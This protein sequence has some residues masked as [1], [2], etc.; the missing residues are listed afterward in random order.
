M[1]KLLR[2]FGGS[3]QF[4]SSYTSGNQSR[5]ETSARQTTQSKKGSRLPYSMLNS[6]DGRLD[7][8]QSSLLFSRQTSAIPS[9]LFLLF[10]HLITLFSILYLSTFHILVL[11]ITSSFPSLSRQPQLWEEDQL[12]TIINQSREAPRLLMMSRQNN[13][14]QGSFLAAFSRRLSLIE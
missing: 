3:K 10:P 7:T 9:I 5:K 12:Y 8:T 2:W 6:L 14:E 1:W 11:D 4:N 13:A